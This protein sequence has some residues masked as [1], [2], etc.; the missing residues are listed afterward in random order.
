MC[1]RLLKGTILL[2]VL[3]AALPGN[4][5]PP[6]TDQTKTEA[7]K[8]ESSS[9][10]RPLT[11]PTVPAPYLLAGDDVIAI[12]VGNFPHLSGQ[13][14]I[15]PDGKIAPQLLEPIS[16][17]GKTTAEVAQMLA[18]KWR[19]YVI[20][21]AVSVSLVQKRK[22]NVLV[23]GAVLRPGTTDYSVD[24]RILA[25]MAEVG[26]ATPVGDLSHVVVTRKTGD[27]LTLDLSRPETKGGT[28]KDIVLEAGDVVYVP[29]RHTQ[30]SVIGEVVKPGSFDYKDDM[31]VLDA[32]TTV[33][34]IKETADLNS[35][36]LVHEGKESKID[37][38]ALLRHGNMLVN[39]KLA[40]GDRLLIPE[41]N[42][43]TYVFG[44]VAHPGYY[45]FKPNDRVL[46]ALQGVGG[47]LADADLAKV[48]LIHVSKDKS[49]A[50][51]EVLDLT[52]F[53]KKADMKA[54][55]ALTPGEVLYVPYRK[56]PFQWQ[57]LLGILAGINIIRTSTLLAVH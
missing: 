12:T 25:A 31:T 27:R 11:P 3:M 19:R 17:L 43:R 13:T 8:T 52:K 18:E 16:V 21:P 54:N 29:D 51:L 4:A 6:A 46:D 39:V 22:E 36:T 48:N 32:L 34:G 5:D 56:K 40:P 55:A 37:L 50:Q 35:S 42:S 14:V 7:S 38:D 10:E 9:L 24:K 23:Y 57:D 33:G 2:G 45:I 49:Q 47:P 53:L 26:G 20:N 41:D 44:A 15:P 30:F 28:E 1:G